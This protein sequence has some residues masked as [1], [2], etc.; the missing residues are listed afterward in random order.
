MGY[1]D[2][3]LMKAAAAVQARI[4]DGSGVDWEYTAVDT[5]FVGLVRMEAVEVTHQYWTVF[6]DKICSGTVN[7]DFS[8]RQECFTHTGGC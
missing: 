8:S 2:P 5:F 4:L 1:I 7:V 3:T 6:T